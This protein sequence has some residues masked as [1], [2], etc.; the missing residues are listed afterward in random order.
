MNNYKVKSDD[1]MFEKNDFSN[2]I[3]S[4][5]KSRLHARFVQYDVFTF[6]GKF[7]SVVV[8]ISTVT[9]AISLPY[10]IEQVGDDE[11][12]VYFRSVSVRGKL[13]SVISYLVTTMRREESKLSKFKK[14]K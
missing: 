1:E 10:L 2:K 9:I 4:E 13:Q 14:L 11:F 5:L 6:S 8:K 3:F 12:V 7:A